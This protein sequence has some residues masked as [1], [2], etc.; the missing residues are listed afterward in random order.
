LRAIAVIP[1]RLGSSRFPN[2]PLIL[3]H[4]KS[5][6][7][8]VYE[9]AVNSGVFESVLIATCDAELASHASGFGATSVMTSHSHER[10]S[11]RT[12][13]AF[14]LW[15]K[16]HTNEVEVIC[17]LQGDEPMISGQMLA[18]GL[19]DFML[20]P[21]IEVGNLMGPINDESEFM[22]PNC[23]K[24]VCD[25]NWD[26]LYMSRCPIPH[27]G[28]GLPPIAYKQVCAIYFKSRALRLFTSLPPTPLEK[29]ESIDMLR[30]LENGIKIR[31]FPCFEITYPV[32]TPSDVRRV[33]SSLA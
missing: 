1:A 28:N 24:V 33:E 11:D 4:S 29:L 8:R 15:Q 17:M 30:L 22:N 19:D 20:D 32:D 27:I 23:I 13:E 18:R 5:M 2:K 16:I 6:I 14:E 10:A 3:I 7:Q 25:S 12:A 31:M 9:N 21:A 26:A